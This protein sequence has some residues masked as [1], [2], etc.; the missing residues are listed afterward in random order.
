MIAIPATSPA[1]AT[2]SVF[3][4]PNRM[5]VLALADAVGLALL[6]APAEVTCPDPVGLEGAEEEG[7]LCPETVDAA[8]AA[9]E[10]LALVPPTPP[11]PPPLEQS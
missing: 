9:A 3:P 4:L 5:P 7:R 10:P 2:S 6:P 11:F 1:A 8:E